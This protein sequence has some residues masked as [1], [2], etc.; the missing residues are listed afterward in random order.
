MSYKVEL[1]RSADRELWRIIDPFRSRLFKAIKGLGQEP[2]PSGCKKLAGHK[3]AWRIRIG[4]F[5]VLYTIDDVVRIVR[6]ESVGDRKDV[7][8]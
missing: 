1:S 7:Y 2:R 6:V 3:N 8:R 5:R 4:N